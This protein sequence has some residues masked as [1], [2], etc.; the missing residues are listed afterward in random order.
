MASFDWNTNDHFGLETFIAPQVKN[1]FY[2]Y[3]D[4]NN[5][6][7][8][9]ITILGNKVF[10]YCYKCK[11]EFHFEIPFSF[12]FSNFILFLPDNIPS[13]ISFSLSL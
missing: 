2:P 3:K 10:N 1:E 5:T 12:Y 11:K 13:L 7:Q 8:D 9:I 4:E 6:L